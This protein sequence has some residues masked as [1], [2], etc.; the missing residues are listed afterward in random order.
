MTR[1]LTEDEVKRATLEVCRTM[2]ASGLVVGSAGNVS[3]RLPDGNVVLTPA[4]VPYESMCVDDLV[5][6][7]EAGDVLSGQAAPTTEKA[8]HLTCLNRHRD[9]GAVVH[10][11]A[12]YCSMFAVTR[13]PIP[14]VMEEFNAYVGGAV[15]VTEYRMTG[16]DELGD[17]VARHLEDRGAV[18]IANHGLIAV[19]K[20]PLDALKVS[21][22]V[23][24][25]AQI[26]WGAKALGEVVP[27]PESTIEKF[28]PYY[29]AMGRN[30]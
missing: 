6:C 25:T 11:H 21:L 27:L 29:K 24:R 23:E 17:E 7:N 26:V 16:T 28:A 19:G 20:D 10:S 1:T 2:L 14:C 22:L 18:L 4:S 9:I 15:S 13:Q 8:L 12:V 30:R 5:V 3:A